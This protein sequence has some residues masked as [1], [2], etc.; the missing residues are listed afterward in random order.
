MHDFTLSAATVLK[1]VADRI[2]AGGAVYLNLVDDHGLVRKIHDG[3]GHREG[4]GPQA[5]AITAHE[6]QSFHAGLCL[7]QV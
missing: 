3:L 7:R 4:K 5:C 1:G 6:N 2:E